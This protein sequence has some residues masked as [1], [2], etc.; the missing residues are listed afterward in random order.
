M[1]QLIV[2]QIEEEQLINYY[3]TFVVENNQF[4]IL[5]NSEVYNLVFGQ[6][7]H[8]NF[9]IEPS[10]LQLGEHSHLVAVVQNQVL[11]VIVVEFHSST[12]EIVPSEVGKNSLIFQLL[13]YGKNALKFRIIGQ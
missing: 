10:L 4:G 5:I 3:S 7:L 12:H 13:I 1:S 6:L 2:P 11:F 9:F 8:L